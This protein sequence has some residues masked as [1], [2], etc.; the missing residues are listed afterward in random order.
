MKKPIIPICLTLVLFLAGVFASAAEEV[1]NDETTIWFNDGLPRGA[2]GSGW[3]W[4]GDNPAPYSGALSHRS[5]LAAGQHEATFNWA[6]DTLAVKTGES[7]FAYVYLDPVNPPSQIMI[8]LNSGNWEHRAYWGENLINQGR[9]GTASRRHLGDLPAVGGWKLLEIPADQVDLEGRTVRGMTFSLFDGRASLDSVGKGLTGMMPDIRPGGPETEPPPL[10][11]VVTVATT[12]AFATIGDP[13]DTASIE[14]TRNG[15]TTNAL[16]VHFT[17]G[18]T[19]VKWF[20]YRRVEGDIPVE[21]VIPAGATSTTF[22]ILARD[23]VTDV[24]PATV[25]FTLKA[26]ESYD[27]GSAAS[28]MITLLAEGSSGDG[29]GND[30]DEEDPTDPEDPDEGDP[31]EPGDGDTNDG[32]VVETTTWFNAGLPEGAVGSGWNWVGSNP[33]PYSGALSHRSQLAAGQHEATFNWAWDTL[34]VEAGESL[35]AYVYLD[36]ANPPSQILISLNSGNWEH[37]AYWGENRINQGIDGTASR[38]H[39]GDLPAAGGWVR[40]EIPADQVDLEGRTVRGMTFSLFNGRASLD[41]VGKGIAGEVTDP[42]TEPGGPGTEPPPL[43]PVITVATTDA[44]ATIGDPSD[45]ASI[46]FTRNGDT[47]NALTVH[48]TLGGTAVKWFD[49]RRVEGDIPVEAVIPAGATSTT[50]NILARDNVTDVDPATVTFTLKANES[51]DIGSAASAMIT[52][53]AEGSSGDGDGN[54]PDEEDPTD[55]EDPDEG[56]PTDPEDGDDGDSTGPGTGD[57]IELPPYTRMDSLTLEQPRVGDNALSILSPTVLELRRINT[58]PAGSS[59]DSWNFVNSSGG[60]NAPDSSRF[61]VSVNGQTVAVTAVGFKRR[62]LYA[63]LKVRDLRIDNALY[64]HLATPLPEGAQVEVTNPSTSL[65]PTSMKF[66]AVKNPLRYSPAIHVNQEGYLPALAK[67]AQVGFY[68]GNLGEMDI[69]LA[70]GFAL[71]DARSGDVVFTGELKRRADVGFTIDPVPYQ[72]VYEADFTSFSNPGQ[73]LLRVAGLGVSLPFRINEG[74]AMNFTRTYALGLYHQRSGAPNE[75]PYTRFTHRGGHMDAAAVPTNNTQFEFTWKTVASEANKINSNNP[76]QIAP[77]LTS[78]ENQLYPFINTGPVDVSGGHHDAGDYSK[79]T[80]NSAALVHELIFSVDSLPGVADLDNLGLPESGDGISDILQL[81]KWEADFLAKMQDADGGFYFLVY[82]RERR[83]ESNVLPD[84][85][86]PQVVWPK[87]TAATA[88]AVGALAEIGSSPRFIAAYPEEAAHYRAVAQKGWDFLMEAIAKHGKAGA[89]QKISHYGD[90]FTHDD[91]LAWA[92]AAMFVATGDQSIHATLQSWY[93]PSDPATRRWGWWRANGGWGNALRAYAFAEQSGRLSRA[94]LDEGYLARSTEELIAAGEDALRWSNDSA[95]G[96]SFPDNTKRMRSA[97]WYFSIP[98]AFDITVAH[99]L[100]PKPA[101][102]D[103]MVANINYELG[104]NPL[105]MVY[106]TGLGR[107][108]QHEI[109]HQYSQNDRRILPLSGIPQGAL[110]TGPVYT[111]TYGTELANLSFPRDNSNTNP[112]ALYDRWTDTFNVATEFVVTDQARGLATLAFLAAQ[113]SLKNQSWKS[114]TMEIT[115][116]PENLP[117]NA[118]VTLGLSAPGFNLDEATIVWESA[119]QQAAF[120]QTY[121]LLPISYENR[122][123]EA[124]ATWPDGRRLFA[125]TNLY[126]ETVLPFVSVVATDP[127]ATIGS[128]T[129]FATFTFTRTGETTEAL[130]IQFSLEGSAVKW[131]DYRRPEGDIPQILTI[132]AGASTLIM[133]IRALG[134]VGGAD[135]LTVDVVVNS[136]ADY[137]AGSPRLATA[138]LLPESSSSM[139]VLADPFDD[140]E[141]EIMISYM[142]YEEPESETNLEITGTSGTQSYES[143]SGTID[144]LGELYPDMAWEEWLHSKESGWLYIYNMTTHEALYWNF[145]TAGTD[146]SEGLVFVLLDSYPYLY[147]EGS[148]WLF[149][150]VD[151]ADEDTRVFY[152]VEDGEWLIIYHDSAPSQME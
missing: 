36:V 149:Y 107:K 95:Y 129:D 26:D 148:G 91:E 83:Y 1:P 51:Y 109:V 58:Q 143:D 40:L 15:D 24:D 101:F 146:A 43:V 93:E 35:F 96:T 39:L 3:N 121:T 73:Y 46:E 115:G 113:T 27:I 80:T 86:D 151:A 33:A 47:T 54:D 48:F 21:A 17:L 22:N 119:G 32:E 79:Y 37:R 16:T 7:L 68:L 14:F 60:L 25:T 9:D 117:T 105:N 29:D 45:T 30:P 102:V 141:E 66:A 4:V 130:T 70:D 6:W 28:A 87:T 75:M 116:L 19:A 18:G 133:N 145:E 125:V 5:Q 98:Q 150:D 63:P 122:W 94:D 61:V 64:L 106:L 2:V 72:E 65:W 114:G 85:G 111:P 82:P 34:A 56:D 138:T 81:A 41:S 123:V 131:T 74:A 88:A 8:S 152:D 118:E 42:G 92:A 71:I 104:S 99:Q 97:G 139:E 120:G 84:A 77:R 52:L 57:G 11:P 90:N 103:A 127:Y 67:K 55:P 147:L 132:P 53:L 134:N 126:T 38:R 142:V 50:F 128:S 144:S 23:N 44:F 76:P 136:T 12:D 49:Y 135:P 100:A 108:R 78:P 31:T 62:A 140:G 59:V 124:E 137:L 110:Q 69:P 13:S 112:F 20:D 10:V 89:Y